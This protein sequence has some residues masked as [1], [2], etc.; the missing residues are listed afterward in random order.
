MVTR[1]DRRSWTAGEVARLVELD[2]D[3]L[4]RRRDRADQEAGLTRV[5][6]AATAG[7]ISELAALGMVVE[8]IREL[9]PIADRRAL[10]VLHKWIEDIDHDWAR[11]EIFGVFGA[12]WAQP[13]G[14]RWLMDE[15]YRV[16]PSTDMDANSVRMGIGAELERRKHPSLL[17]EIIAVATD[18]SHGRHRA[19]FVW[20]LRRYS[21]TN[22]EPALLALIRD[23]DDVI[24]AYA[25]NA[26]VKLK[27]TLPMDGVSRLMDSRYDWV[28]DDA[29]KAFRT[30]SS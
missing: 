3:T 5:Y 19:M 28:R 30:L 10:P 17:S 15:F 24:A 16:D 9:V 2:P 1:K 21:P 27:A 8:E 6:R 29:T 11:R 26:L 13:E 23:S 22:V 25:M 12:A 14:A 20:A 18:R 7:L 4:G